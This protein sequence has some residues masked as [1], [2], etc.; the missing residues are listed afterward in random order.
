MRA[1]SLVVGVAG[2]SGAGKSTFIEAVRRILGPE[3][4][5][6]IDAD[7]YHTLDRKQRKALGVTPLNPRAN[8]LDLL[9]HH[10]RELKWGQ[11]VRK[12]VYDHRTGT[13][14][15]PEEVEPRPIVLVQGLLPFYT[16]ALRQVVDV[17]VYF[18]THPELKLRWKVK[19]DCESR[20]YR[21]EEVLLEIL[22]R[23][24]DFRR[25]VEAQ[26]SHADVIVS[27]IPPYG[28]VEDVPL[29]V[30]WALV[31]E[32]REFNVLVSRL[33]HATYGHPVPLRRLPLDCN[34][35]EME[36]VEIL[37]ALEAASAL[38][39]LRRLGDRNGLTRA[40]AAARSPLLPAEVAQLLFA[41]RVEYAWA[42][43][44]PSPVGNA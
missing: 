33:A 38:T 20:G 37:G 16:P 42:S 9:A 11:P 1:A 3:R 31:G 34:G 40:L 2:D 39:L 23:L 14:G 32:R 5:L 24:D 41:W 36:A 18:D 17:K 10:L 30:P 7:D 35:Q 25:Y 28:G 26:K 27:L 44:F 19:R 29:D 21:V 22:H 4:V 43:G 12:P 15:D 8:D 6:A 13:F